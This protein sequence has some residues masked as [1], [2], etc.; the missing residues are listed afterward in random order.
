MNIYDDSKR[1]HLLAGTTMFPFQYFVQGFA[2]SIA[3]P[4]RLTPTIIVVA[5]AKFVLVTN[6]EIPITKN[7]FWI[8]AKSNP[9]SKLTKSNH[10][11]HPLRSYPSTS[12]I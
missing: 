2:G 10:S 1:D 6:R 3:T 5:N 11:H 9:D 8:T 4:I 7:N 12:M